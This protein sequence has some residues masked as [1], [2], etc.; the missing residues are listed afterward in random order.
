MRV[1]PMRQDILDQFLERRLSV[2]DAASVVDAA[3][4]RARLLL[5]CLAKLNASALSE[6]PGTEL[7]QLPREILERCAHLVTVTLVPT[8]TW[9]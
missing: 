3:T 1:N 7:M 6:T 2:I 8:D 5:M 4:I 9:V